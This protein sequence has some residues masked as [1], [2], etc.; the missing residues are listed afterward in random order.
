M[1]LIIIA[2]SLI[3][4]L[5]GCLQKQP[6]EQLEDTAYEWEKAYMDSDYDRQQQ[7]LY[8]K[9]SFTVDENSTRKESGLKRAD[10]NIEIY[11]DQE[12]D[13]QYYVLTDYINPKEGNRVKSEWVLREK[14]DSW[15]VDTEASR[16]ITRNQ[17]IEDYK[18]LSC[19]KEEEK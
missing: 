16:E 18:C 3:A 10:V 6:L 19:K 12:K 4:C 8:K 2:A 14:E 5:A 17:V 1:R 7:L 15:K 9:G 11:Q 13:H